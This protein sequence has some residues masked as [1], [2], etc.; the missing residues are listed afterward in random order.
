MRLKLNKVKICLSIDKL[1]E[2]FSEMREELSK[3]AD[4]TVCGLFDYSL[5]DVD[6]FIG[7][8]LDESKL[9][10]ANRLKAIFAY[11]A[12]IDGFPAK[13][14]SEMGVEVFNSHINSRYIA[15][16]AFSLAAALVG[17]VNEFDR[18]MR[19]GD[20]KI[21]NPYWKSIFSLK[22]GI[23]GYGSI[24]KEIH[25]I[26]FANGIPAYTLDRGK[27]YENI[28]AV[29]SLEELCGK[30]DLIFI[31]LPKT[32]DTDKMFDEHIFD[33]MKG[34][35]IVNVGRSNCI[36][37]DALYSAL[38]S[39]TLAGAAIDTWREKQRDKNVPLKPFDRPFDTLDNIILSSHKAMQVAD[40]HEKY[41]KDTLDNVLSYLAGE[42]PRNKVNLRAGY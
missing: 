19:N 13:K 20:W 40:G 14:L 22:A 27:V 4:V 8:M 41:V 16:Y 18:S 15:E 33:L 35:Y 26:L 39:G 34:K 37:E 38:E 17:R 29:P 30:C 5:K 11:K 7:K 10:E 23:V 9:R 3:V 21:D 36:D 1:D 6:I 32:E 42:K 25:K 24:G 12:G 31:A 2:A 28:T